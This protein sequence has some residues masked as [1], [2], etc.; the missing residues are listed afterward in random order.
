MV[1]SN[2]QVIAVF[3]LGV[4]LLLTVFW[5][6]LSVVKRGNAIAGAHPV[7]AQGQSRAEAPNAAPETSPNQEGAL[8]VVQVGIFGTLDR[9]N[10][11][12][13]ELHKRFTSAYTES[14]RPGGQDP[15]YRVNIGP[16]DR[17]D[18]ADQ[19]AGEL[20]AMGYKGI[21]IVAARKD[22]AN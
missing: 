10:L 8:Y 11:F 18:D 12:T 9:A 22:G 13:S 1:M 19:V 3:V 4:A 17:R 2:K 14:P 5:A 7:Q 20:A 6:G 16:Y 15:V 21:M